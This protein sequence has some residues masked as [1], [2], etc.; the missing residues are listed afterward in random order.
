MSLKSY[1][2]LPVPIIPLFSPSVKPWE[3]QKS[4][5]FPAVFPVCGKK[6]PSGRVQFATGKLVIG[7]RTVN[8]YGKP[9]KFG[10]TGTGKGV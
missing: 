10:L 2:L 4:K 5:A 6:R 3:G 1:N 9:P 8:F 7:D